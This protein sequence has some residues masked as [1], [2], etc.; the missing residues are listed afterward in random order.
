MR[1]PRGPLLLEVVL[2]VRAQQQ[3]RSVPAQQPPSTQP[4]SCITVG[5]AGSPFPTGAKPIALT[6]SSNG[7]LYV[8]NANSATVSA[9]SIS[10]SSGELTG[11]SGSP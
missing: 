8:A 4:E 1:R 2:P 9:F 5:D 10:S 6:V 11:I 7:F 3:Q